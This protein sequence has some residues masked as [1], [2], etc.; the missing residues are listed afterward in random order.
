[1]ARFLTVR[2]HFVASPG[3]VRAV[4]A[5]S[6]RRGASLGETIRELVCQG[7]GMDQAGNR[8]MFNQGARS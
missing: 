3:W 1:M 7:L 8:V 2:V 5:E 6:R 4:R